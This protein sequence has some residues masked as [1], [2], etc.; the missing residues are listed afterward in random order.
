MNLTRRMIG[1]AALVAVAALAAT[2]AG[3]TSGPAAAAPSA[4]DAAARTVTIWAD[5]DR[6][7]AVDRVA[8]AWGAAR[9]VNVSVVQKDFGRIRDDLKTVQAETAPDVIVGAHDWTGELAASGLVL[10]LFPSRATKAQ[11]PAY[12]LDAFSY[13]TAV[14][15]LYG[16][17]VA[18]EN[19]GLVVNTRLA[20]V[21]KNFADLQKQA[22]AFKRKKS[23]NLAIA[24]QQGAAGDAYHMYPF[25]SGLCGYVFGKNSAGNLDASNIGVANPR[26]LR[27]AP[28]IDAWN[29]TGLVNAKVDD[30][31][32]RDAFLKGR[33]AFWITGP[34]FADTIKKAGIRFRVVQMPRIRCNSVPFLGVQGFMVTKFAATHGVESLAKDLVGT[35]MMSPASQAALA[36]ANGRYPANTAAGRRVSDT[37]LKQFGAASKGGVPMPNIPQMSS[38]WSDL[39]AAWVKS[40]KGAG[41]TKA[42]VSFTVAA[43]NIA[44]KIG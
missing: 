2:V 26:F 40:T 28:L 29:K 31:A 37:V 8:S 11:F 27:N 21:P 16:A 20:K 32:A 43:L 22:L 38:V 34:W 44:N 3:S 24:V 35:Y 17:P 4:T 10:P 1:L 13:G 39:G 41:A 23:G 7:A 9:G 25:F 15:R 33:A 5:A 18:V 36:A 6:K 12:T 14:K 19:I 42:R 30:A